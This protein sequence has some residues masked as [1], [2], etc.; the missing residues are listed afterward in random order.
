MARMPL[1]VEIEARFA[2]REH[3]ERAAASIR[4]LGAEARALATQQM[5]ELSISFRENLR[6]IV[7]TI[8]ALTRLQRGMAKAAETSRISADGLL[9]LARFSREA[10]AEAEGPLRQSLLRVEER[11]RVLSAEYRTAL[12]PAQERARKEI[13]RLADGAVAAGA[14]F[15]DLN[16]GVVRAGSAVV[17]FGEGARPT[18]AQLERLRKELITA[19][20]EATTGREAML[21][22]AYGLTPVINNLRIAQMEAATT[23]IRALPPLSA[24]LDQAGAAALKL[25]PP[26]ETLARALE[27][28]TV[29]SARQASQL[30]TLA[31]QTKHAIGATSQFSTV[32]DDTIASLRNLTMELIRQEEEERRLVGSRFQ[33]IV[34]TERETAALNL[35]A[36]AAHGAMLAMGVLN[37]NI[38]MTAF[39]TIFLRFSLVRVTLAFAG[40]FIVVG[41]LFRLTRFLGSRIWAMARREF[42][43]LAEEI[44]LLG[45]AAS[46]AGWAI[47]KSLWGPLV[48]P[49]FIPVI[50]GIR[51]LIGWIAAL[52]TSFFRIPFVQEMVTR[53]SNFLGDA[54]KILGRIFAA[55]VVPMV[56]LALGAFLAFGALFEPLIRGLAFLTR[57]LLNAMDSHR[58]LVYVI[59]GFVVPAF[60]FLH[61]LISIHLT[62]A[63]I[64]WVRS[65][66]LS[67]K[68]KEGL[69]YSI[70]TK[71]MPTLKTLGLVKL[72]ETGTTFLS[73]RA[74]EGLRKALR[75][76]WTSIREGMLP[77]LRSLGRS[78]IL[79]GTI[80]AA[81]GIGVYF[82]MQALDRL[83]GTWRIV[84][85]VLLGLITALFTLLFVMEVLKFGFA[86]LATAGAKMATIYAMVAGASG[87]ALVA[88]LGLGDAL[89]D[90][91][92]DTSG[93]LEDMTALENEMAGLESEL[94]MFGQEADQLT[95]S[96]SNLEA[97]TTDLTSEL[98]A[99]EEE[100][101]GLESEIANVDTRSKELLDSLEELEAIE[102]PEVPEAGQAVALPS[103][104]PV[105]A[106]QRG[107]LGVARRPTL[108]LAGERAPEMV[109]V[110]R[111]R[112]VAAIN[113]V[114]N[115]TGNYILDD[116]VA[117][118][119]ADRTSDAFIRKLRNIRAVSVR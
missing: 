43:E 107:F 34:H 36:S 59:W 19:A 83:S 11:L 69:A 55:F 50:R 119:L 111:P 98:S 26:L 64:R 48:Q 90:L 112:A 56:L 91:G 108:F 51:L 73:I 81:L 42:P 53:W 46:A 77:V 66:I 57:A 58:W 67:I 88:S 15:A 106:A 116:R 65:V 37:G 14:G 101:R 76:L 114:V 61:S 41:G 97:E 92:T 3:W 109:Y 75:F 105:V 52:I 4:A 74:T 33:S 28:T 87:T 9:T 22:F 10:A 49:V 30:L 13:A 17:N 82:L 20:S 70:L 8:P 29:T 113:V 85:Q 100:M 38:L 7:P 104:L 102:L 2:G 60:I 84:I 68:A 103:P 47:L 25:P 99:L 115:V 80:G 95:Q 79:L 32:L 93:L 1:M 86:G 62:R 118:M 71:L 35:S 96:L 12:I 5:R 40:L 44:K 18:A 39:S 72:W 6:N 89:R 16:L 27:R 45:S 63:I 54:L 117:R 21:R 24:A 110:G 78:F 31:V 23:A 94:A